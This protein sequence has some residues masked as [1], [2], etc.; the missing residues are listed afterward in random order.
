[1]SSEEMSK[2]TMDKEKLEETV[3]TGQFDKESLVETTKLIRQKLSQG[4]TVTLGRIGSIEIEHVPTV[5][6]TRE[7]GTVEIFPPKNKIR[8]SRSN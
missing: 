7:D 5:V 2:A 6:E 3:R 8:Y 4:E 1:M